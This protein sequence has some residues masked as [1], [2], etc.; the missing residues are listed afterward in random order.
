[1]H[2]IMYVIVDENDEVVSQWDSFPE[3]REELRDLNRTLDVVDF[4]R[5]ATPGSS[6]DAE[7][8]A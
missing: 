4:M 1:M 6:E 5:K 8:E 2:R 3:A 7:E